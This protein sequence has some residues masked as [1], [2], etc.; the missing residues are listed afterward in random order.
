V[1]TSSSEEPFEIYLDDLEEERLYRHPSDEFQ[2][3]LWL[4]HDPKA[5]RTLHF[6]LNELFNISWLSIHRFRASIRRRDERSHESLV[7]QK[8][9]DFSSQ[10]LRYLSQLK[11]LADEETDK[12]QK[13]IFLSLIS[14]QEKEQLFQTLQ[15]V[16]HEK[17][18]NSLVEIYKLFNIQESEYKRKLDQFFKEY[19]KSLGK[20]QIS[21]K[22]AEYLLG[23][24][25]IHGVVE[26]WNKLVGMRKEIYKYRDTFIDVINSLLQRK[27]LKFNDK[28]ELLVQTQSGKILELKDLSSG[29]KQ[30]VILMGETLLQQSE[31]HIFIADEPE[32]SLHI[33][34]QEKLV[35]SLKSLNPNCQIIFATHSPDVVSHYSNSV[36]QIEKAIS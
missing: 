33:E 9:S 28:N 34:W 29:E 6:H 30:L 32:L 36:I 13:F 23:T 1:I 12:F 4:R 26:E 35:D 24:R 3:R 20:D 31:P 19:K 25:R 8:I 18:Q 10:L 5:R 11:N 21:F 15:S 2:H 17:E 16:D 27:K 7:D 22:E 14:V